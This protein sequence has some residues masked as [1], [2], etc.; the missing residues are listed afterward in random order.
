MLAAPCDLCPCH[1][2]GIPH[3]PPEKLCHFATP[4]SQPCQSPRSPA[5]SQPCPAG[6]QGW[7]HI[8]ALH[9]LL[10]AAAAPRS[11]V[12]SPFGSWLLI[13]HPL[14][15]AL[16]LLLLACCLVIALLLS[17]T[18]QANCG[19]RKLP[20]FFSTQG[21]QTSQHAASHMLSSLVRCSFPHTH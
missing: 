9:V 1:V 18:K 17:S 14:Q 3:G 12:P 4:R 11:C 16:N 21:L 10:T 6:W 20:L 13:N 15:P 5:G 8:P 7:P 19:L 2:L